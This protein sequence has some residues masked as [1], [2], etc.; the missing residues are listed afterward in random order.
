MATA[1]LAATP[2]SDTGKGAA[3]KARA[4]GRVP[5]VV[6]GHHRDPQPVS[7]EARELERL[8]D[9]AAGGATI[10]ELRLDGSTLQT[11]VREIQRH[12]FKREILHVDFQ[13]LVAGEKVTVRI[14]LILVGVPSEVRSG[15]AIMDQ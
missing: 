1:S 8:L 7:V 6:Y 12:P 2:R 10:V 14:P 13:E 11:L 9:R 15:G 3:R 5:G 4:S